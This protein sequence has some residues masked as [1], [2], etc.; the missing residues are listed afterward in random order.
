MKPAKYGSCAVAYGLTLC[1]ALA[2]S[3]TVLTPGTS[4][5]SVE[6]IST[7]TRTT[8]SLTGNTILS[9]EQLNLKQGSELV[10]DFQSGERVLNL[11]MGSKRHTIDG[12][13]SSNGIVGFFS[14]NANF[15]IKGSITAK[16]VVLSTLSTDANEFFSGNGYSLNG[17]SNKSLFVSGNVTGTAGDVVLVGSRISIKSSSKVEASDSVLIGAGSDVNVLENSGRKLS[18]D[19][20]DGNVINLGI[21]RSPNIEIVA[22]S[23]VSNG[24]TIDAGDGQVFIEVGS[25]MQITNDSNA[26]ILADSIFTSEAIQAGIVIVPNEGD[27]SSAVNSG[28]LNMPM[29]K[30]PDGSVVSDRQTVSASAPVSASGDAGRDASKSQNGN[31]GGSSAGSG[32]ASKDIADTRGGKRSLLQRSSF[33][34]VRGGG[35]TVSDR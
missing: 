24:E 31:S 8:F 7:G 17:S 20:N 25:G 10:Y 16:G 33:F 32:S 5:E 28:T 35:K 9:W 15:D 26:V 27:S 1:F 30:R 21:V 4:T 12:T 34:G 3:P 14:P 11:L 29:L 23:S 2:Q 6:A 19:S 22:G 13:V 18:V